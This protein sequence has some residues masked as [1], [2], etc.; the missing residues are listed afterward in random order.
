MPLRAASVDYRALYG[1]INTARLAQNLSFR[2][3]ATRIGTSP[4]T[5]TRLAQERGIDAST[6]AALI[7]WLGVN[8]DEFI[9]RRGS[10]LRRTGGRTA[11]LAAIS[12]QLRADRTLGPEAAKHLD[13][14][15]ASAYKA[16]TVEKK[17]AGR[18]SRLQEQS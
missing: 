9:T 12:G 3:L 7:A 17:K 6:F 4:S 18:G 11:T 13:S 2:D 15:I 1:A 5:F 14:I 8:A 16:L 10:T